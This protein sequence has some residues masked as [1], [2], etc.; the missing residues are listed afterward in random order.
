[1]SSVAGG[2]DSP[3]P[4]SLCDYAAEV[5]GERLDRM[6]SYIDGVRRGDASEPVHQMRVWSRR[7]RAALEIFHICF[8]GKAFAE[9]E[10][11]VKATTDALSEARDLDVMMENLKARADKLPASHRTGIESLIARLHDGRE[12]LQRNVAA[13]VTDLESHNLAQRFRDLAHNEA[14]NKAV[15]ALEASR[16]PAPKARR[17]GKRVHRNG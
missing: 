15:V 6:L 14:V 9:V 4:P 3:A 8:E 7:S 2:E 16:R 17:N 5:T 10:R 1:M 13:A 11:E 12:G